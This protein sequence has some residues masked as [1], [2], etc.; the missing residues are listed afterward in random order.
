MIRKVTLKEGFVE[1]DVLYSGALQFTGEIDYAVNKKKGC[2][3]GKNA[4][5]VLDIEDRFVF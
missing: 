5:D 2:P 3:V 4:E 1:C